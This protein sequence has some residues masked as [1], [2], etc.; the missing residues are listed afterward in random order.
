MNF[1]LERK[2]IPPSWRDAIVSVIPKEGKDKLICGNYRPA[3]VLNIDYKLFTAII[4]QRLEKIL[5]GIIRKDQTGFIRQRQTQDNIR[6]TLHI[7]NH[8]VRQHV[9]TPVPSLDAEKAFDS[10]RW[11]FLYK[12]MSKFGFH[13]TL[14]EGW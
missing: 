13:R 3:S 2:I 4:S 14:I 7:L 1:V 5:T 8:A 10:V 12:V 9:E 6:K 11:T